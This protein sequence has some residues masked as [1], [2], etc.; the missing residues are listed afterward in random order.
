[1]DAQLELTHLAFHDTLTGL[2]NRAMLLNRLKLEL[3][4]HRVG[5][6]IAVL[7][8]DLDRFKIVNDSLGHETGDAVLK[9]VGNRFAR[10]IRAGETAA[11]FSGDEFVFIVRDIESVDDAI[12]AARRLLA[13]LEQPVRTGNHDL[14]VTGSVGIVIPGPRAEPEMVLRDADTAMYQAKK[15]GRNTYA[16]FDQDLHRRSVFRL[17]METELRQ[18]LASDSSRCATSRRWTP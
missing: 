17:T 6:K 8:L 4:G 1:M 13:V 11:R 16:L 12:G 3:S 10:A 7:F 18:A 5:R 2:P 15:S 9:E 14:T